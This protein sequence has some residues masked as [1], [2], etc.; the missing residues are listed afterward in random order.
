MRSALR[1]LALGLALPSAIVRGNPLPAAA[2]LTPPPPGLWTHGDGFRFRPLANRGADARRVG[3]TRLSPDQTGIHFIHRL[4][5]AAG[6]ARRVLENGSGTAA[7]DFDGDDRPDLF[8]ASLSGN[9]ALYRNLGGWRFQDVTADAGLNLDGEA[10]RG[11]VFADLNGN[12]RPDLL[13]ATLAN[14]LRCFLNRGDGRFRESTRDA[15]PA[16]WPGTTT[17]AL[18]DVD[19]DG[20]LDLY[21]ARYRAEDV[22]DDP[23]VEARNVGGRTVLHPRYRDRLFISPRGLLEFGEPDV[24]L[25]NDGTA[26]FREVPWTGGAFLDEAGQPLVAPPRDWGLSASFR[27][28]NADGLP[29]LYVCNDYWTPDRLWINA[30]DGRFRAA[31]AEALRHTSENS[32]GVDFADLDGDGHVDFL[33]LDMLSRNPALRRR[34]ALAQ[35]P[36]PRQPGAFL[37]RPQVMRN[38]LFLNRGDGTFAE[39]ADFAGLAASDWSWQPLFL[40]VDLDGDEDVVISA[41]HRRDVQDLDATTRVRSL[42]RPLP[43]GLDPAARLRRFQHDLHAHSR[44]YPTLAQPMVAFRHLRPLSFEDASADWGFHTAAVHQGFAAADFDRDGDLD[45]VINT[46]DGP[47]AVYRNDAGPPRLAVRLR[48][49]P[50]N[51][52]GI[53]AVVTLHHKA[54]PSQTR[55]AVAGGRYLSGCEPLLVFAT[56]PEPA[57]MSLEIRWRSGRRQTLPEVRP[58]HLYEVLEPSRPR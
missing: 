13:V 28:L 1:A 41:G 51:T 16:V 12:G 39:I 50:P 24:L 52:E 38:T 37:D 48:G 40:D 18:A 30:G 47:P 11:A 7:G 23:N 36:Q 22:R 42:Q 14:G 27:D 25:L 43:P 54:M 17:L 21:V 31:P 55:E 29:D 33:V 15:F 20:T 8:L 6:A 46:L 49:L 5:E 58:D 3:F 4:D 45:L 10:V 53:G 34:Q 2:D 44:L 9:S 57:P 32:M 19:G 26:R 35:T 56:G